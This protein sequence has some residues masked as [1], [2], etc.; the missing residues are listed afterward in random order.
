[1]L[2]TEQFSNFIQQNSLFEPHQRILIALSGGRDSVLLAHLCR[3]AGYSFALAH[4]NFGLRGAESDGDEAFCAELAKK[5]EVPFYAT[6]VQTQAYAQAQQI[7]IQMA[8]REFRYTWLE[9]I[10]AKEGYAFV[11]TAHHLNDS[12]ETILLNL[13][14]GTG[15]SGLHGILPKR[16]HIIR[17]LLFL[18]QQDIALMVGQEGLD[19]REDSSNESV[20]YARNKLR[21]QVVPV[22]KELN[23]SLE[24]TFAQNAQRMAELELLLQERVAVLRKELGMEQQGADFVISLPALKK[25]HPLKT[26]LFELFKPYGFSEAVLESLIASWDGQPGKRLESATYQLL[27]DRDCVRLTALEVQQVS[28]A[29]VHAHDRVVV[30]NGHRYEVKRRAIA[31]FVLEKTPTIAQLDA[32]LLVYPLVLRSWQMGDAYQPLGLHGQ[33]KISDL[34]IEHKIP[35]TQ[36]NT[37]LVLQNGDG[38]ILWV[39]GMRIHHHHQVGVNTKKVL[40]LA[41]QES[42]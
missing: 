28:T 40:I 23:P 22:L 14:R 6:S 5:L 31:D 12:V 30:W 20:K 34:F 38:V 18:S 35:R 9:Q 39:E 29:Y 19:Y 17:P 10:R 41:P 32:D 24:Q 27:L 4:V 16:G 25:L 7:S 21:L 11:A 36:K 1:M 13:V 8:A 15:V 33:K 2:N 26:L 37:K 3:A 42:V